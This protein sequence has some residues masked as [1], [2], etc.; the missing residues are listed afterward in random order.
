MEASTPLLKL[1]FQWTKLF[2]L[3]VLAIVA[4]LHLGSGHCCPNSITQSNPYMVLKLIPEAG[5][6]SLTE[7]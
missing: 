2:L 6:V 7:K 3:D 1:H 4:A 5:Q